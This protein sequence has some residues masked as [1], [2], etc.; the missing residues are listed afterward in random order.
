MRPVMR[1]GHSRRRRAPGAPARRR[2]RKLAVL[3]AGAITVTSIAGYVALSFTVNG[4]P[5]YP[6][7]GWV[8]VLQ[9]ATGADADVVPAVGLVPHRAP[10]VSLTPGRIHGDPLIGHGRRT[11]PRHRAPG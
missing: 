5:P 10:A 11:A 1:P 3:L 6:P 2:W 7:A 4:L 9:P 8:A